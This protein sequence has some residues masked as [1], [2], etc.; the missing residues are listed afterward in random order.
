MKIDTNFFKSGTAIKT[1]AKL[2]ENVQEYLDV[3]EYL[4]KTFDIEKPWYRGVSHSKYDLIPKVHR[5]HLWQHHENFEWW[6]CVD[7]A[8]RARP[9]VSDHHYYSQWHWYFTM[10]HYGFPTRLLDWTEGSLIALYFAVRNSENSYNPS[11]YFMNPFWF[12]ELVYNKDEGEG[13]IYNTDDSAISEEHCS[14]LLSYIGEGEEPPKY[15][16]CIEPPLI[17][18]RMQAQKSVFTIH[19]RLINPFKILARDNDKVQIVKIRFTTK[20]AKYIKQQL[21][22]MGITEGALFPDIEGLARD[23]KYERGID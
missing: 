17:N 13:M 21:Y 1:N 3:T 2:L 8:N 20:K 4:R 18:S 23:I 5:D 14:R 7:F 6:L 9:F 16:L 12:D 15:P 19:G 10:Q 22:G 11:V